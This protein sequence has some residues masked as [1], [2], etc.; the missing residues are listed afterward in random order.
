MA[1]HPLSCGRYS[2]L[3]RGL[4]KRLQHVCELTVSV[5]EDPV[6]PEPER[7]APAARAPARSVDQAGAVDGPALFSNA[8]R[9]APKRG[10]YSLDL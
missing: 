6:E 9:K 5:S 4:T 2:D 1:E 7:E 3:V 8:P 10:V